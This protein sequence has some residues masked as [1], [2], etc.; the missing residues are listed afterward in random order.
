MSIAKRIGS[1]FTPKER[2]LFLAACGIFLV[3]AIT[4]AAIT[5][6]EKSVLIPVEGGTYIEGM[7]GQPIMVNPAV[8]ANPVDED[9]SALIYSRLSSLL[10]IPPEATPDGRI[11]TLKL[12]E[13]LVWD[14]NEPLT[15]DDVIFTLKTIQ[16]PETQSPL[17]KSWQGVILERVSQI[18]VKL[19]LPTPYAF[20]LANI[21]QVQIIPKH[22]FGAIPIA[23]LRLSSY[24]LQP[25]G[26]GPYRF[27]DFS[28]RKDGFITNYRLTRNERY[29]GDRPF[30]SAFE[31][32][33]Y[34]DATTLLSD[35]QSRR[36]QGFGNITPLT[37]ASFAHSVTEAF[38]MPRYYSIFFNPV[39]N[40]ALKDKQIRLALAYA[41]DKKRIAREVLGDE[42]RTIDTPFFPEL[43]TPE[44]PAPDLSAY[45][46][47]YSP[48]RAKQIFSSIKDGLTL[49]LTVPNVD[50]LKHAAEIIKENWLH[51]GVKD[52]TLTVLDSNDLSDAIRP[53]NFEAILFGNVLDNPIDVFPFW[54]SS[55]RFYPGLNLSLYQSA[56]A[57]RYIEEL[58]QS[59]DRAGDSARLMHIGT[60][61]LM[62]TPAI[63]LFTEPYLYTHTDRLEGV[64]THL[65]TSPADRF[66]DVTKW[67]ITRARVL[68]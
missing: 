13:G 21:E 40:S 37:N 12:K 67:Y 68:Q 4:L 57:D 24:N 31:F 29:Q 28:K 50:F 65:L 66:H 64:S 56:D 39:T 42:S 30:I 60:D 19:T 41:I 18:Q 48:D 23:N 35:F 49:N 61:I 26:N 6:R 58:R 47:D 3:S 46:P 15:A 36:I 8:S 51:A 33:F 62:D 17:Q 25:V 44:T 5:I 9:L 53:R 7:V 34:E 54:H 38:P 10:E 45:T 11:Y 2:V 52:V 16:D 32:R 20:L 43:S 55:Q 1:Q 22:I 27:L 14:D 59:M 63:F